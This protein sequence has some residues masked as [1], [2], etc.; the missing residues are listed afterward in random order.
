[1][2][3]LDS[4]LEPQRSVPGA[5]RA[6]LKQLRARVTRLTPQG[7]EVVFVL[8]MGGIELWKRVAGSGESAFYE[9]QP[10]EKTP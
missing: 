3:E 7:G 4:K 5:A 6:T 2:S 10:R 8:C 9:L 1:M